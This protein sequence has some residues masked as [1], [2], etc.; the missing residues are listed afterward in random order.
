MSNQAD[1]LSYEIK[2]QQQVSWL[3]IQRIC[4]CTLKRRLFSPP[5]LSKGWGLWLN[6]FV[7]SKAASTNSSSNKQSE[8]KAEYRNIFHLTTTFL[9]CQFAALSAFLLP[10]AADWPMRSFDEKWPLSWKLRMS[11]EAAKCAGNL[12]NNSLILIL[13]LLFTQTYPHKHKTNWQT[14]ILSAHFHN[15]RVSI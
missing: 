15:S 7:V 5:P 3:S 14:L 6:L 1:S 11:R 8:P 13:I 12:N 2:Q 10:S 9:P 4:L